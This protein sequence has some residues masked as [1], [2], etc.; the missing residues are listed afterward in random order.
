MSLP[1]VAIVGAPN[2]GKS[3]LFNRLVGGR[4]A[5]VTNEP[6]VTRDRQYGAVT[7]ENKPFRIVDTGGLV[8]LSDAP[9]AREIEQ[10]AEAALREAAVIVFVVDARAGLTPLDLELSSMLRR[11]QTPLLLV[12]N[13]MDSEKQA[14]LVHDL[15]GLGL[16]E[17]IPISAEHG[18]GIGDLIEQIEAHLSDLPGDWEDGTLGEP[19]VAVRVAIVGK[20][21]VGKSS[22]FNRLA[23]TDRVM[24]SDIPGTTRDAV[25]TLLE[26]D[27]R[28]Y[29]LIDTAGIRRP[30]KIGRGVERFSVVHA[31]QRIASAD[32]VLLVLDATQEIAA[33]D[34]HIAGTI[35]DS[36]K[37]ILIIMNKWDLVQDR[38]QEAKEWEERVR[39]R[40]GFLKHVPQLM[41]SAKTGQRAHRIL[42][43]V[44]ALHELAGRWVSTVDLNQWIEKMKGDDGSTPAAGRGFR[45]YYGTQTG[46]HPP[47]FLLFCNNRKKMHFS[48]ERHIENGIRE[49]FNYGSVPIRLIF[50]DRRRGRDD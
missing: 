30:G 45:L 27:E 48:L 23:G 6:G 31:K 7:E 9:F 12:A 16:G 2:V 18:R 4:P 40:L 43:M 28:K 11:K 35:R 47:T 14:L 46:V 19:E 8:P 1:L 13:K 33:Q 49:H 38:E 34:T 25:D 36:Y 39:Y 26:I 21:N 17:A 50:R 10:Q 22:L 24:V 32:V 37:P 29:R 15:Y 44:D 20:P 5:I 42:E 3:T 41:T